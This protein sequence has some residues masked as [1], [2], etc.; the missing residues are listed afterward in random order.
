MGGKGRRGVVHTSFRAIA[1]NETVLEAL[2]HGDRKEMPSPY[3]GWRFHRATALLPD[4]PPAAD[5]RDACGREGEATGF[6]FQGAGNLPDSDLAPRHQLVI[7]F[8]V[9]AHVTQRWTWRAKGKDTRW[10]ST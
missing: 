4:Q 7:E 5:A 6:E 1:G 9:A 2:M 8:A 3:I 10:C